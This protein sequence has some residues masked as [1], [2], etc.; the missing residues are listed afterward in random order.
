MRHSLFPSDEELPTWLHTTLLILVISPFA[1]FLYWFGIGAILT[2]QLEP[3]S[4]PD[5]GQYF[6]GPTHLHGKAARVAGISLITLGC[7]FLAIA[8]RFSR[9]ANESR[10]SSFL[11]WIL[12][13]LSQILSLWVKSIH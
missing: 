10:F 13:A 6:F 12:L 4:G 11:P 8:Y 2:G 7:S 9:M 3:L 5:F 1:G